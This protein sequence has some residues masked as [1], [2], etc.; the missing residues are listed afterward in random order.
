MNLARFINRLSLVSTIT[1][2]VVLSFA[3]GHVQQ[4]N[5]QDHDE[6]SEPAL[7]TDQEGITTIRLKD[8][9]VTDEGVGFTQLFVLPESDEVHILGE[10][11]P[12]VRPKALAGKEV[13]YLRIYF[14]GREGKVKKNTVLLVEQYKTDQP[15]F[16]VDQNNNLDFTDDSG[17]QKTLSQT[18]HPVI[19]L[20]GTDPDSKFSFRLLPFRTHPGMT[21]EKISRYQSMFSASASDDVL[22]AEAKYWYHNQRLNNRTR[23]IDLNGQQLMIGLHDYDCDGLYSGNRDR[24]LIGKHNGEFIS[25]RYSDGAVDAKP[26]EI[27]LIGDKPYKIVEVNRAGKFVRIQKS[28][29]MPKR[30]FVGSQIPNHSAKSLAGDSVKLHE[31]QKTGK[32]MVLDFWGHWCKPCVMAIPETVEFNKKWKDRVELIG[33]HSGEPAEAKKLIEQHQV[34]WLQLETNDILEDSFFIDGWP[35]YVL[36]DENGK[37]LS[38]RTNLKDIEKRLQE[39]NSDSGPQKDK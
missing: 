21:K 32:L 26:G 18:P 30:L 1:C 6:R 15:V 22:Y 7:E 24:L 29:S 36:I 11:Y 20:Q 38:F 16:Y 34:N 27:F 33:I 17:P 13:G 37:L 2:I 35:T 25:D 9:Q 23:N 14:T 3:T 19:N 28:T 8:A 10:K 5:G 39:S 12:I 4:A 31:L